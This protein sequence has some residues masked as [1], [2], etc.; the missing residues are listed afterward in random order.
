M[1]SSSEYSN[2]IS[3][4]TSVTNYTKESLLNKPEENLFRMYNRIKECMNT[5]PLAIIYLQN[6]LDIN[7]YSLSDLKQMNY[8]ELLEIKKELLNKRNKKKQV[9]VENTCV[10]TEETE[11]IEPILISPDDLYI[12][13]LIDYHNYTQEELL[14]LGF[15]IIDREQDTYLTYIRDNLRLKLI[16]YLMRS[17]IMIE[18]N[19][20]PLERLIDLYLDIFVNKDDY[21]SIDDMIEEI[22]LEKRYKNE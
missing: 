16:E 14:D 3:Y 17:N 8:H 11:Y 5:Y 1:L 13:Y 2:I 6:S 7:G 12:G 21:V 15:V 9:K 20:L 18:V 10:D 19:K 4:L 22:K